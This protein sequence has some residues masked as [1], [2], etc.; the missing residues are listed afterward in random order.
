MHEKTYSPFRVFISCGN[1]VAKS[2]LYS[3]AESIKPHVLSA[4]E[5]VM[6][7]PSKLKTTEFKGSV[8]LGREPMPGFDFQEKSKELAKNA[9][10]Y[11]NENF[12]RYDIM[13]EGNILLD[14]GLLLFY[15][16]FKD[17]GKSGFGFYK[18]FEM[19][20]YENSMIE[21]GKIS[22][23]ELITLCMNYISN[24]LAT[25]DHP[26]FIEDLRLQ[27]RMNLDKE[28]SSGNALFTTRSIYIYIYIYI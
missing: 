18:D 23:E 28:P 20:I 19:C 27:T 16:L 22:H 25:E 24:I 26:S 12:M 14:G 3:I 13:S 6:G 21:G 15:R 10:K 1:L 2:S 7:S 4:K 8:I 17:N 11:I 5:S 9:I